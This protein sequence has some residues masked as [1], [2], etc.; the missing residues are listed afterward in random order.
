MAEAARRH[1]LAH[2][3]WGHRKVWAMCRYEGQPVS[4]ASV[5]RLLQDQGLLLEANYQRERRQLAKRRKAAFAT[6]HGRAAYFGGDGQRSPSRG[7][8]RSARTRNR[9]C[10]V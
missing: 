3:D 7:Q 8:A 4:Q 1:A 6:E 9:P 10:V 5:L 2:P